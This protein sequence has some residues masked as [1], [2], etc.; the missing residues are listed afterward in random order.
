MGRKIQTPDEA[1]GPA[2]GAAE[3]AAGKSKPSGVTFLCNFPNQE[4][5]F[6]DGTSYV[7]RK[8]Q[9]TVTD[10]ELIANLRAVAEEKHLFEK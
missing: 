8:S 2:P 7:V 9:F 6:P 3:P 5:K 10:P 4:I 1:T